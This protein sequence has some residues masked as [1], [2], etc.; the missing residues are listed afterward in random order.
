M[1]ALVTGANGFIGKHLCKK[2]WETGWELRQELHGVDVI[3]HLAGAR[4]GDVFG[5]NVGGTQQILKM[6]EDFGVKRVVFT[7]SCAAANPVNDYGESKR[8]AEQLCEWYQKK[9]GLNVVILRLF[10][11]YGPGDTKSDVAK[12]AE[13]I[14][15][16]VPPKIYGQDLIRDYIHVDDVIRA[17]MESLGFSEGSIVNVGTGVGTSLYGLWSLCRQVA[18]TELAAQFLPPEMDVVA[19]SVAPRCNFS[20]RCISL[21]DG[22]KTVLPQRELCESC[23]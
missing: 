15:T 21:Y 3:F 11:V 8:L 18:G 22:L 4:D 1:K 13:A 14:K 17:T 16:G 9:H 10:N 6:A 12:F 7:S 23:L 2:L 5:V 19:R 20:D